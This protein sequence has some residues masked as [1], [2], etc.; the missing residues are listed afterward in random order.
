MR[1]YNEKIWKRRLKIKLIDYDLER[2][3]HNGANLFFDAEPT[4]LLHLKKNSRISRF[5][6]FLYKDYGPEMAWKLSKKGLSFKEKVYW[7][8]KFSIVHIDN[9]LEE[10]LTMPYIEGCKVL[11]DRHNQLRIQLKKKYYN[12]SEELLKFLDNDYGTKGMD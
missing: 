10:L 6:G 3:L 2:I 9:E 5:I 4:C 11:Q 7:K 12:N 8:E 1:N